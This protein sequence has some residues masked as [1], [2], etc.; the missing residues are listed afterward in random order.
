MPDNLEK[1]FVSVCFW[2]M[3]FY[4]GIGASI[5]ETAPVYTLYYLIFQA[6]FVLAYRVRYIF[7]NVFR[8]SIIR[9]QVQS[10]F[11]FEGK[12]SSNFILIIYLLS[13]FINLL[14][15]E[16]KI[17]NLLSP[18]PPNALD[19]L[20]KESGVS[21]EEEDILAKLLFYFTLL[22]TPLYY[23]SLYVYRQKPI[24]LLI[25]I[26]IP[27][28]F[29]YCANEY[30][31]RG[32]IL[33]GLFVWFFGVYLHN[34]KWRKPLIVGTIIGLP[35]VLIFFIYYSLQRIGYEVDFSF[36]TGA[37]GDLFLMEINYPIHF[38]T[39]VQSGKHVDLGGFFLWLA[40]LPFPKFFFGGLDVPAVNY[41]LAEI[42]LNLPKEDQNFFVILTGFVSESL[43]IFGSYF[44]WLEAIIIAVTVK[45][46]FN[47][48]RP[49]KSGSILILFVAIQ[50]GFMYARAGIASVMPVFANGFL[51]VYLYIFIKWVVNRSRKQK[52]QLT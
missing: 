2:G 10:S 39:I 17:E 44:F 31:G 50:F 52:V 30:I 16:V 34:K 22:L 3:Y 6:V 18:P 21:V 7:P 42:V 12:L 28:Y 14:Y 11:L 25:L 1:F 40:T 36:Q 13:V 29:I 49:I 35:T 4:G 15:P 43:Y 47:L 37:I 27:L 51:A 26:L 33:I 24:L 8:N 46:I 5:D 32:L 38:E 45:T 41:E 23:W 9:I 20:L 48:L 19:A